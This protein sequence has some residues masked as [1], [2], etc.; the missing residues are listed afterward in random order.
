MSN[1]EEVVLETYQEASHRSRL[2]I[3]Y[4]LL[5]MEDPETYDTVTLFPWSN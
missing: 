3:T 4:T 2:R 1:P 5:V